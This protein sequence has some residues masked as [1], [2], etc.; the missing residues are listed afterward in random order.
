MAAFDNLGK[1]IKRHRWKADK[2]DAHRG[3]AAIETPQTPRAAGRPRDGGRKPPYAAFALPKGVGAA[4]VMIAAAGL[5]SSRLTPSGPLIAFLAV[6]ALIALAIATSGP[7]IVRQVVSGLLL[8]AIYMTVAVAFTL[9]IGVLNFLN[10]TIPT[11]FMLTGMVAWALLSRGTLTFAGGWAWLVALLIGVAVAVAASM[12]VERFTFR[13]LKMKHGDA[14]EHAIPLVSSLGFLLIFENLVLI[15]LGSES[16]RFAVPF[17]ADVH[18]F[19]LVI[20]VAQLVSCVLAV[21]VVAVL[22][23]ILKRTKVGRALRTIAENPDTASLLGVNVGRVVPV[24]FILTGLLSGVAGA[25]FTVNYGDVSPFMGDNVG[26][27]AIAAMVLGG[28]GSIWGAIVGGLVVGLA[29]TLS[30]QYFGGDSV[31]MTVWGLVL[32]IIIL[33]PKGLFAI[34]SIGKGKM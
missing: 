29:E 5:T 17:K 31:A 21:A 34:A 26:T 30:I 22:S 3:H 24:V 16:Q 20:G 1:G 27:K 33:R 9:T 12:L 18:I 11:L 13:Y 7:V 28:I 10:F 2:A 14:T 6:V 19:G 32:I 8:G 15:Q 23:F 4:G 25:L